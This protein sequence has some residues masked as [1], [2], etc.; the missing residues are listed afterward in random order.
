MIRDVGREVRGLVF[1]LATLCASV[2]PAHAYTAF[3]ND[4]ATAIDRG[5]SWLASSGAFANP[6]AAGDGAGLPMLA[7][8]NRQLGSGYRQ[9]Y[10][11]ANAADQAR[12][13][14]TAAYLL[15]RVNETGFTAFRDGNFM[16][17]LSLYARTGGPDKGEAP[18]IPDDADYLTIREA[19][20]A[21]VDR[22][23]VNQRRAPQFMDP[24]RQGYWC[25]VSNACEDT[26]N[27]Q[28][29]A[30]G[31]AA[32][33]AYYRESPVPDPSRV[34]AISDTLALARRAFELNAMQGSQDDLCTVLSA[35]ERGH[36][37]QTQGFR[38]ALQQTTAGLLVQLLGG[39]DVNSPTVQS[40]LEWLRNRYRWQ[41]L[42]G[43]GGPFSAFSYWYYAWTLSS[44]LEALLFSYD[45]PSPGNLGP[46]DLGALPAADA[47][48]CAARQVHKDPAS[49]R[50]VPSFGDGEPG[51]YAEERPSL[52]FDFAHELLSHQCG[53]GV[54]AGYFDC[55]ATLD[56]WDRFST[57]SFALL[58]LSFRPIADGPDFDGDGVRDPD[59]NCVSTPNPDQANA[60]GDRNGDPC[61]NC[62]VKPNPD[63]R[64]G[65]GDGIGDACDVAACDLD[66]DSDIDRADIRGITALRGQRV[67]PAPAAADL[68]RNRVVNVNDSRGCALNCSRPR[69]ATP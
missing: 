22:A 26:P 3:E 21:L 58:A 34:A 40:Y 14:V 57:Q 5:F 35:T 63:Q 10:L 47:P 51:Y 27:T 9:G 18:E 59:D 69:C 11:D 42:V 6:S 68:D 53:V 20:N 41:D 61:D 44:T 16:L 2:A 24:A 23:L 67:P 43:V 65:D 8:L 52:Y 19:I 17:A 64:D 45:A 29:V 55:A 39:A 46:D 38:P 32:A 50:R 30:A 48:A 31:L 54:L 60:D 15:D 13:R 49:Y 1:S 56:G 4:L 36:P 37:Y 66:G 62:P 25:Y 7:L 33:R 28:F 12:L